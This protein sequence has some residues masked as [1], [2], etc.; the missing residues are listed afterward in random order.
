[1]RSKHTLSPSPQSRFSLF[2][3]LIGGALFLGVLA[4]AIL[5]PF[6]EATPPPLPQP[7]LVYLTPMTPVSLL[8]EKEAGLFQECELRLLS[9]Q[10]IKKPSTQQQTELQKWEEI[11]ATLRA[12]ADVLH[13]SQLHQTDSAFPA[14]LYQT[15]EVNL[16]LHLA[17]LYAAHP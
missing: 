6:T 17:Q 1:M 15:R 4:M 9:L 12:L 5:Q 13:R 16:R 14:H 8:S 10:Q 7:V 3:Q 11:Q 2:R